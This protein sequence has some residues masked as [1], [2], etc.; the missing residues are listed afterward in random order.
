MYVIQRINE[1]STFFAT[2][3]GWVGADKATLYRDDAPIKL[4]LPPD[5]VWIKI[6]EAKP[7]SAGAA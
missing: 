5:G 7:S 4:P 6:P 1:P 2:G 3:D